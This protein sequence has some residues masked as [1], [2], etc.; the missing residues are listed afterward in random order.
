MASGVATLLAFPPFSIAPLAFVGLVPL[1]LWLDRPHGGRTLLRG[2]LAFAVPYIGGCIYWFFVLGSVTPVAFVGA[3]LIVSMYVATFFIFPIVLNALHHTTRLPILLVAPF[4]WVVSEHARG[5]SDLAFPI[6]TLGY[7]LSEWPSLLQHAD[8]VGVW[9]I[10]AWIVFVNASI[11]GIVRARRERRARLAWSAALLLALVLPAAYGRWRWRAIEREIAAAPTL[12][13]AVI[14]PNIAQD[15]KWNLRKVDEIFRRLDRM[16]RAAEATAPDLVVGPEASLPLVQPEAATRLPEVIATGT[17]PLLLGSVVGLGAGTPRTVRSR[18]YTVHDLH[19]N[20][21]VLVGADRAVLGRHDKVYLV[22]VVERIPYSRVFGVLLPFMTKQFGRF[23]PGETLHTLDVPTG[24]GR[25]PFG[26][27]VCYESLFPD[28]AR[29]LTAQGARFLVNISNDAWFGRTSFPHQHAGFCALRAIEN[30][31]AVV[32]SANTGISAVYDPLG[33]AVETT[34]I[35][36]EASF[37][38]SVPLMDSVTAYATVGET[39]L[40]TSYGLV[41]VCLALAWRGRRRP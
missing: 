29:R 34:E 36:R 19:Y 33:R 39:I 15:E 30:R 28:L 1:L 18:T 22:P 5:Y 38:T 6:L 32:R 25:V 7:A 10:S 13:V 9:G 3:A 2:G 27:L 14:Q 12:R 41:A 35:F 24:G 23:T 17:R 21:A 31:R 40:F 20:A 11:V 26:S 37:S 8:V 4:V 16:V